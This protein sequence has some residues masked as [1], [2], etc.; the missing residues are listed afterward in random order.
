LG[1]KLV[2]QSGAQYTI[3]RTSWL[4]GT[5]HKNFPRSIAAG[6]IETG[7]VK[8]VND[9]IG[10]PTWTRD[11][12]E[13]I[14]SHG[15]HDLD[16]KIV[17]AASSGSTSWFNFAKIVAA[18]L[19]LDGNLIIEPVSSEELPN[20]AKRP[21]YS[22]LNNLETKGPVIPN[23]EDRWLVAAPEVLAEFLID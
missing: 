13:V 18:S 19:G 9:Q 10:T 6:L 22:V 20:Q 2:A 17:H 1:E 12:A 4:Y 11:L 3:F 23:W 5:G 16:E 14:Y 7:A 15:I 8:V 21:K